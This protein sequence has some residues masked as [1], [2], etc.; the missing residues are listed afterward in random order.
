MN[1]PVQE[2]SSK[3]K[4][5]LCARWALEKKAYCLDVLNVDALSAVTE[6]FVICT[7]RSVRQTRA[8]SDHIQARMK[9]ELHQR[10]FGIEGEL[11]NC[12][13]LL[14]CDDVIV[15]IF[16]EPT[17]EIYNL[18]KLWSEAIPVND[19]ELLRLAENEKTASNSFDNFDDEKDDDPTWEDDDWEE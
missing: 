1:K 13:I 3:D 12:W 9:K 15:H 17:R 7:A 18:E 11:E 10:P 14:D 5:L 6:Y 2:I 8:I 4:A 16:F 19:P